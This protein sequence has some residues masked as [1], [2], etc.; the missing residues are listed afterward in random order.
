MDNIND[1]LSSLTAEDMARLQTMAANLFGSDAPP[2]PP[3]QPASPEP[4]G[5]LP[6]SPELLMK[7]TTVMQRMN[8][9][10]GERY[11]LIEALKPNLSKP[12]QKKAD[13]AMQMLRVLE[14]LPLLTEL[15]ITDNGDDN[16][17]T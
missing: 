6:F 9:A 2:A 4:P 3:A 17:G 1:I 7:L 8:G 15:N 12:R 10:G 13:E 14:L 11:K 5:G 16:H